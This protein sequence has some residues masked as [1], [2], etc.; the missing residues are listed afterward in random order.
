MKTS[1]S[2]LA[3][4]QQAVFKEEKDKHL[5][6]LDSL[7]AAGIKSPTLENIAG[8]GLGLNHLRHVYSRKKEDGLRDVL[9]AKNAEGCSRVMNPGKKLD[10]VE[11]KMVSYFHAH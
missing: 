9:T 6:T 11:A 3:L 7:Q 5:R 8:S 4:Q 1:F 10:E 2:F